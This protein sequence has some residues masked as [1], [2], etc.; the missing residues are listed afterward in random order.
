MV[1]CGVGLL[2]LYATS[3]CCNRPGCKSSGTSTVQLN[4]PD[5]HP[6]HSHR[7]ELPRA[8]DAHYVCSHDSTMCAVC[9]SSAT[10]TIVCVD[11]SVVLDVGRRFDRRAIAARTAA[12]LY[13]RKLKY[14]TVPHQ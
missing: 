5:V 2:Y 8:V 4:V 12:W 3:F 9:R 13:H 1:S 14:D 11:E 10:D 6:S 7:D